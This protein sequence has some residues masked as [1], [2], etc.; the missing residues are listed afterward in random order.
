MELGGASN[1]DAFMPGPIT[2]VLPKAKDIPDAVTAGLDSVG[3]ALQRASCR[4]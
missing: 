1:R 4:D 3:S 2:A